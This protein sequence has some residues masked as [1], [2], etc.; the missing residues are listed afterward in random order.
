MAGTHGQEK[1]WPTVQVLG[2]SIDQNQ[3]DIEYVVFTAYVPNPLSGENPTLVPWDSKY[4]PGDACEL[5]PETMREIIKEYI[6]KHT[7]SYYERWQGINVKVTPG[8]FFEKQQYDASTNPAFKVFL[9]M[10]NVKEAVMYG[11][12]TDYCVRGAA[13]A[14]RKLGIEVYLV[15]DAIAAVTDEGGRSALEEMIAAGVKPVTTAEVLRGE[16]K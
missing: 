5:K 4:S 8:I 9:E 10:A 11:V 1:F 15:T 12:A 3:S 14:M 6:S 2:S 16:I 7:E 13:L